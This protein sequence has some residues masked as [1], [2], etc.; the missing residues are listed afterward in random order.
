MYSCKMQLLIYKYKQKYSKILSVNEW[1]YINFCLRATHITLL[2]YILLF[3]RRLGHDTQITQSSHS[4]LPCGALYKLDPLET[5]GLN[6]VRFSNGMRSQTLFSRR[7]R[8]KK[9]IIYWKVQ[10]YNLFCPRGMGHDTRVT[11]SLHSILPC[12]ALY[13]LDP[14]ETK[15]LNLVRFSMRSQTL[16]SRRSRMKKCIIYWKVQWIC[17]A[18]G[19]WAMILGLRN[20]YI[21]FCPAGLYINWT[22]SKQRDST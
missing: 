18:L 1:S 13:K 6:L 21:L 19:G 10:W 12:G 5:K 17:F 3:P 14:L 9:C 15:G 11:Q 4:I 8:M 2:V 20:H 16:F 7:S 22:L